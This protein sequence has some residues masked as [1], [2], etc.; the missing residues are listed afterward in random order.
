MKLSASVVM[1]KLATLSKAQ[2]SGQHPGRQAHG[3]SNCILDT[4]VW[5]HRRMLR[6]C[7]SSHATDIWNKI[8]ITNQTNTQSP[9]GPA[10]PTLHDLKEEVANLN[11]CWN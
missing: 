9:H 11:T 1:A 4:S 6:K 2:H 5:S 7:T 8:R 3:A 10:T